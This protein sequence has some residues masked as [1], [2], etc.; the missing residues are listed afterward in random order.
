MSEEFQA[1]CDIGE[2]TLVI[3][4]NCD[5]AT[6]IEVCECPTKDILNEEVEVEKELLYTPNVGTIQDLYNLL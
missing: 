1:I 6:N 5:Y 3:C 2:D 4:D